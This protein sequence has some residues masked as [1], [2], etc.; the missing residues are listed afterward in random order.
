MWLNKTSLDRL[1][2]ETDSPYLTP[3][4]HRGQQNKPKHVRLVAQHIADLKGVSLT[5][6]AAQTS[7]NF[8]QLFLSPR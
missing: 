7:E 6:L 1:L 4:P 2:V 5:Q 8:S 3:V